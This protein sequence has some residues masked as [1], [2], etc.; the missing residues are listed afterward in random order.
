[1]QKTTKI[2]FVA[3]AL[4]SFGALY[5][6]ARPAKCLLAVNDSIYIDGPCDFRP[7]T[8]KSGDFQIT[9]ADGLYF[10]Y[11]YVEKDGNGTGHWNEEPGAGHAHTPL[12]PLTRDGACWKSDTVKLCAW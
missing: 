12:G 6:Q 3:L 8:G 9:S 4:M 5:A 7:L 2:S 11:L 1:M 10:A